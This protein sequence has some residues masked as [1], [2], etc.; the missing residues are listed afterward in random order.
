MSKKEQQTQICMAAKRGERLE[1]LRQELAQA[2]G[3]VVVAFP[4]V[5]NTR[6]LH[7]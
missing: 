3:G 5:R 7:K 2:E 4:S 6:S 1:G